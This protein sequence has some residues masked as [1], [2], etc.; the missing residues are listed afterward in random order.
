MDKEKEK[1]SN[2]FQ[3]VHRKVHER[4]DRIREAQ[5]AD[6]ELRSQRAK[7]EAKRDGLDRA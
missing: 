3:E 5:Q 4:R 1:P 7:E 6:S 2:Q